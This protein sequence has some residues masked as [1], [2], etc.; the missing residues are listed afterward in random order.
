MAIDYNM[1]LE[2]YHANAAISK[3][4]LDLIRRSPLHYWEAYLNPEGEGRKVTDALRMGTA[5]HV[6]VLEPDQYRNLVAV[7]PDVDKRTKAGKEEWQAFEYA[8]DGK[9]IVKPKENDTLHRMA[10]SVL[11]KKAAMI[12][13][14]GKGHVEASLFWQDPITLQECR[15][16]PD[17]L[18]TDGLLVDLK[19][20]TD[21]SPAGFEKSA[22]N[23][24]YHVQAAFYREGVLRAAGANTEGF[25]FIAVE[26]E[27]PYAVGVYHATEEFMRLG[28][29]DFRRDMEVYAEAMTSDNWP[30]YPD[31][32]EPLA[33]PRWVSKQLEYGA[34]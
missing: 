17:W 10:E 8:N 30:G 26:K 2:D 20:T 11:K 13:L 5:F 18:R 32:I 27:P 23:Y 1:P 16:R 3:S 7:A 15:C 33:L 9:I 31:T 12:A 14:K 28:E 21:A 4:G 24:R 29:I 6:L 19:T 34:E 22:Y 25:V